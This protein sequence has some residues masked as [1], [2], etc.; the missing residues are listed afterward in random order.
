MLP[1]AIAGD[2]PA[3]EAL[4]AAHGRRVFGMCRRLD[5]HPE[6]AYQE[7]WEKVFRS[8]ARFDT[9]SGPP[10]QAWITTVARRHLVDRH[11]RRTV[12]GEVVDLELAPPTEP[13]APAHVER[14]ELLERLEA[15]LDDLPEA[16]RFVVVQ[17]HVHGCDLATLSADSGLP[18]GT[19]KSR[20]HRGR[21]RLAALLGR[22]T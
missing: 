9:T 22:S 16:Q 8:L 12:R 20:L 2:R 4:V 13:E 10:L 11:R 19:L 14:A 7:I 21:A 15:A 18:V 3:R 6:D 17:H 5:P 1:A